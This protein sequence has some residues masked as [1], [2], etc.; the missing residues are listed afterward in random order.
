MI[1]TRAESRSV[2]RLLRSAAE[3]DGPAAPTWQMHTTTHSAAPR[4]I[5]RAEDCLIIRIR[6]I[7]ESLAAKRN[8]G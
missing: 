7:R 1:T 4:R 2:L 6:N 8:G 3:N 5:T